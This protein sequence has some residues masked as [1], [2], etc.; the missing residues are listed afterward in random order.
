MGIRVD[1]DSL[2]AQL[3]HR[4]ME[5]ELDFEFH[6]AVINKEVPFSYGGGLGISR[7]L[8]LLLRT[9]HIG[10]VQCGIW[11]DDHF[12]QASAAGID[13]IPDRFVPT[14]Y[15]KFNNSD[16]AKLTE[17]A[18]AR[19]LHKEATEHTLVSIE[20]R[21]AE[22]ETD[23]F[24][25]WEQITSDFN[26]PGI[27]WEKTCHITELA[28][29]IKELCMTLVIE[30][31]VSLEEI[32]EG[33]ESLNDVQSVEVLSMTTIPDLFTKQMIKGAKH[34]AMINRALKE[35]REKI[36][37]VVD[38]HPTMDLQPFDEARLRHKISRIAF[39]G[40]H[41]KHSSSH[42][43]SQDGRLVIEIIFDLT[44]HDIQDDFVASETVVAKIQALE[45]VEFVYV[46]SMTVSH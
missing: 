20:V 32:V 16:I 4:G 34:E 46:K 13:M 2:L 45:E 5:H 14:F 19:I 38:V 1:K 35:K 37:V 30:R 23:V 42:Y 17:N 28:F 33:I 36:V 43:K 25:L 12:R 3:K 29:G 21:P 11:H 24:L 41:W 10:E 18:Q 31:N 26:F 44:V 22:A 40:I 39:P 8:M 15:K 27:D 7:I 9:A 6:K